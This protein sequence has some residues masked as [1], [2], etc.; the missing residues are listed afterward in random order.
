MCQEIGHT[1]GLG[2]QDET[3]GN[4]NL[5]TCMDYTS[6]PYAP[7][8]NL[9]LN[10]HDLDQLDTIYTHTDGYTTLTGGIPPAPPGTE[11]IDFNQPAEWGTLM[12]SSNGGRTQVFERDFGGGYKVVHFVIWAEAK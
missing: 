1:L 10:Q 9:A 5:G 7:P 12:R 4:P 3:F 6:L 11:S 8:N 2:H